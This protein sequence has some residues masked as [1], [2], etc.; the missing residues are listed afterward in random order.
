MKTATVNSA[1]IRMFPA[2]LSFSGKAGGLGTDK[3]AFK[4]SGQVQRLT[5]DS[6]ETLLGRKIDATGTIFGTFDASG[7]YVASAGAGESP[8]QNAKATADFR[9]EDGSAFGY[10]ITEASA[11]LDLTGNH[12]QISEASLTSQE[13]KAGLSGSIMIDTKAVDLAF[14]LAGFDLSRLRDQLAKYAIV[15]GTARAEGTVTGTVSDPKITAS[16]NIDNLIINYVKFNNA[17]LHLDYENE[18]IGNLTAVLARGDQSISLHASGYNVLKNCLTSAEGKVTNISIPD[19]WNIFMAS[20]YL[21]SER[22]TQLRESL[23]KMP[24]FTSGT[25]NG[26]FSLSGCL[27]Q[28]TG[29]IE[30]MGSNVGIDNRKIETVVLIANAANGVVTL[31][32]LKAAAGETSISATG[33]YY[34]ATSQVELDLSASNLDLSRLQ[35]WLGENTPGGMMSADFSVSGDIVSPRIVGSIEVVKPSFGGLTF[36]AFRASR[37]EVTKN[38]VEFADVIL[39]SGSHQVVAYGYL[40]W[41]WSTWSIPTNEPIQMIAQMKKQDL[42]VL[43]SFIPSVEASATSGSIEAGLEIGGTLAKPVLQGSVTVENGSLALKNFYNQ[44]NNINIALSFDGDRITVNQFSM[45][46]SLGGTLSIVP[47][48]YIALGQGEAAQA[49]LLVAADNFSIAERNILGMQEDVNLQLNAGLSVTGDPMAPLV[50]DANVGGV[51]GGI[52]MHDARISFVAAQV[53]KSEPTLVPPINPTFKVSIK[54][55]PNVILSPPSLTLSVA[56]NGS[57]TGT[58]ARPVV[59][60]DPLTIEEGTLKLAISRLSITP[61]G[62]IA[63]RYAPPEEPVVRVNMQA[64]TNVTAVNS[65]GQRERY[66]ITVVVSGTVTDLKIDLSSNPSG[67]TKEQMLAALGHVS[68]IFASGEAGLQNELGN[69]LT[70]VGTSTIFAPVE[71]IFVEHLGFEQFTLEYGLGQPLALYISRRVV[72][73]FYI[74]YY[75]FL[76]SDF[77]SPNDVAYL[78]GLSYRFK[79]NY[80]A[81]IFV[82]DQQNGSFQ[83]QYTTVFW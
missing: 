69:I 41:D 55:G 76:T 59:V 19:L 9:L 25:L 57:I 45:A 12:L 79:R 53:P 70:A 20:P 17:E 64:K 62:T 78:L 32:Q 18:S 10:P 36:D 4:V 27:L 26:T 15:G 43:S 74:S 47:G 24:K 31:N 21:R 6:L 48:G 80:Q 3:I 49:N 83:V 2:E 50:A 61:G 60:I 63:I 51:A 22:G 67:L 33:R 66:E 38:K 81:T 42:S 23:A 82:D 73:N 40:P 77:T 14:S 5:L 1:V 44:F 13:A 75:G 39:A 16:A 34:I 52:N 35:P 65:L 37:I 30:I 29:S 58:L 72:G 11:H 46:S 54:V 7:V 28:P 8:L 71:S 56:G 68:G